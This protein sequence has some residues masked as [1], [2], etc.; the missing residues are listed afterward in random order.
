LRQLFGKENDDF[1]KATTTNTIVCL[2]TQQ[3]P[4]VQKKA[5]NLLSSG[6]KVQ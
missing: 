2:K 3:T 6:G 4:C 1:G 5:L